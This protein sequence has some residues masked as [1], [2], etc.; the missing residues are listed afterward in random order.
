[1][2]HDRIFFVVWV[3]DA[4]PP[5]DVADVGRSY[6]HPEPHLNFKTGDSLS[7]WLDAQKAE[8]REWVA[9]LQRESGYVPEGLDG[10][11]EYF[12]TGERGWMF[13]SQV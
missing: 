3:K 4:P 13:P 10:Y 6:T 12:I 11:R 8:G 1:M 5:G 7:A 9:T 2:S